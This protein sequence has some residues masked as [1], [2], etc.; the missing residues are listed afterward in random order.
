MFMAVTHPDG[1]LSALVRMLSGKI[2]RVFIKKIDGIADFIVQQILNLYTAICF[3]IR[4][5]VQLLSPWKRSSFNFILFRSF[6]FSELKR[7]TL[8]LSSPTSCMSRRNKN[9]STL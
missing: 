5:L 4:N 3:L 1:D 8:N 9:M 2:F 7:P 6:C